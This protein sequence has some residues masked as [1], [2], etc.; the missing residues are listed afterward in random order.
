MSRVGK[1]PVPIPSG[2]SATVE[3][4]VVKVKGPKGSLAV[5]LH[6][7]VTAKVEGNEVK[8]DPV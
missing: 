8:V 5:A 6:G 1:K 7:D 3:G 4:H 2:V